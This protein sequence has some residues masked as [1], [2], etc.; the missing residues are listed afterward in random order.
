MRSKAPHSNKQ[1]TKKSV[2]QISPRGKKPH[3]SG[4]QQKEKQKETSSAG[5]EPARPKPYDI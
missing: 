1:T 3:P 2:N 5:F 4:F